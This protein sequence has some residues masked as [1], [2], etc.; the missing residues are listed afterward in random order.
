MNS[1][2][3]DEKKP[4]KEVVGSRVTLT[5]SPVVLHISVDT[6]LLEAQLAKLLDRLVKVAHQFGSSVIEDFQ[7]SLLNGGDGLFLCENVSTTGADSVSYRLGMRAVE[8]ERLLS[9]LRANDA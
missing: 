8:F 1:T 7:A 6:D 9:T 2:V 4:Q 3:T 5:L